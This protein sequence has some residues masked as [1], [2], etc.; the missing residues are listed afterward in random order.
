MILDRT[1]LVVLSSIAA[2]ISS[3]HYVAASESTRD[4]CHCGYY[5]PVSKDVFTESSIV[6]FNET[7]TLPTQ[8][9]VAESYTH[10]YDVG[11]HTRYRTGASLQNVAFANETG[12]IVN[13]SLAL[14][15]SPVT[16]DH[17]VVGSR[18]RTARR[19]I[20]YGSFIACLRSPVKYGGRGGTSLSLVVEFNATQ[21]I[22]INLQNKDFPSDASVSMLVNGEI[23]SPDRMV[24]YADMSNSSGSFG[25]GT[26]D[27]WNY[28]EFRID[29]TPKE[30][31]F[32]IGD[33]LARSILLANDPS[34]PSVPATVYLG[35]ASNGDPDAS[36]GPP[37]EDTIANVAWIRTFF[38]SSLDEAKPF[39]N[40]SCS[41]AQ[42]CLVDDRSLRGSSRFT[43]QSEEVWEQI[44]IPA[45]KRYAAQWLAV[46]SLSLSALLLIGPLLREIRERVALFKTPR[47]TYESQWQPDSDHVFIPDGT[48]AW[49]EICGDYSTRALKSLGLKSSAVRRAGFPKSKSVTQGNL[50]R[51]VSS[52]ITGELDR[53]QKDEARPD[54]AESNAHQSGGIMQTVQEDPSVEKGAM[55]DKGPDPDETPPGTSVDPQI[56]Q[57]APVTR[58]FDLKRRSFTQGRLLPSR[59]SQSHATGEDRLGELPS[60]T[61]FGFMS[62]PRRR[63]SEP[64]GA[65][66][67]NDN[68]RIPDPRS[69][70]Q[71]PSTPR[72]QLVTFRDPITPGPRTGKRSSV[73]DYFDKKRLSATQGTLEDFRG[74]P[75]RTSFGDQLTPSTGNSSNDQAFKKTVISFPEPMAHGVFDYPTPTFARR[76]SRVG[77]PQAEVR[78]EYLSGILVIAC[79]I[80]TATDFMLTFAFGAIN[81]GAFIHY[82][83]EVVVRKAISPF[84]FNDDWIGPFFMISARF[85]VTGY[86]HNGDLRHIAEKAVGRVPRFI[87][88]VTAIVLLEYFFISLNTTSWLKILP[89]ITWTSWPLI[90]TLR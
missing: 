84:I 39:L 66:N 26:I 15:V 63:N 81:G 22:S 44:P 50:N 25:K 18:I 5:D 77:L 72:E 48:T 89:S 14:H 60:P 56:E 29:W 85:L 49:K 79:L 40:D 9:L 34:I 2:W 45:P 54:P 71:V 43:Q 7:S 67:Q 20:K 75:R 52:D 35:H 47:K 12:G 31:R 80:I 68:E 90:S 64:V 62:N 76:I 8:D 19:D 59:W 37:T 28:T 27:P 65:Q 24:A 58:F 10:G 86:I 74:T 82:N 36:Q 38:N 87:F 55:V 17:L 21:S 11:W 61:S 33:F 51:P 6:Y 53:Y 3:I 69:E 83:I 57:Q 13:Q 1:S 23:P 41:I 46:A 78:F 4:T 16:P 32:Y 73:A 88:P 70:I 42:A 30:L